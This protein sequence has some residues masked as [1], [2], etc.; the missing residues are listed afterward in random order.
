MFMIPD[1]IR[2]RACLD[3][4]LLPS[5]REQ[6]H[7]IYLWGTEVLGPGKSRGDGYN[8]HEHGLV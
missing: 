5:E 3:P 8:A 6:P 1:G 7:K 2:C 4:R